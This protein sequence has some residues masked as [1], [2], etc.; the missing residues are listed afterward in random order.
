MLPHPCRRTPSPRACPDVGQWQNYTISSLPACVFVPSN[1]PSCRL[2]RVHVRTP[3]MG[4][5]CPPRSGSAWALPSLPFPFVLVRDA[6]SE[7]IL[8]EAL[9][10]VPEGDPGQTELLRQRETSRDR[11]PVREEIAAHPQLRTSGGCLHSGAASLKHTH[12]HTKL[13][14]QRDWPGRWQCRNQHRIVHEAL[15]CQRILGPLEGCPR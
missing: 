14:S 1:A 15:R 12:T 10:Q 5:S 9:S 8:L 7:Q 4:V 13:V 6:E 11:P 2:S 3:S